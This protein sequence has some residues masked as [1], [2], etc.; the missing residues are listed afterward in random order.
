MSSRPERPA[1]PAGVPHQVNSL[2]D[3]VKFTALAAML[4][5]FA[6]PVG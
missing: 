5:D 6:T 3:V 4:E 1:G 2:S